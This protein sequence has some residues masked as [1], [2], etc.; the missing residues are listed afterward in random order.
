MSGTNGNSLHC[1]VGFLTE[2]KEYVVWF[3]KLKDM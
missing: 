3:E 2:R 1:F